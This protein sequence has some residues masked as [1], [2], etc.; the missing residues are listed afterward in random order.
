MRALTLGLIAIVLAAGLTT[1]AAQAKGGVLTFQMIVILDGPGISGPIEITD[2]ADLEGTELDSIRPNL[3]PAGDLGE[4]LHLL[5]YA[6][7]SRAE[8]PVTYYPSLSG[9]RG[10]IHQ[11]TAVSVGNGTYEPGWELPSAELET[12]LRKYGAVQPG[13]GNANSFGGWAVLTGLA[14][15]TIAGLSLALLAAVGRRPRA[16]RP[17]PA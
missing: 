16:G 3:P 12:T 17:S 8:I 2:E 5:L 15:G 14:A 9:D 11:E 1:L 13:Q 4:A 7:D 6:A 10:Y